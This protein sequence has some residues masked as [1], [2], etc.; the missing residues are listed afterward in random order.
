[1]SLTIPLG[2]DKGSAPVKPCLGDFFK[3]Y[4]DF[5]KF[6]YLMTKLDFKSWWGAHVNFLN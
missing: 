2:L 3:P 5:L 6:T 4:K 1:M